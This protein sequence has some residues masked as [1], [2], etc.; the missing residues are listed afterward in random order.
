MVKRAPDFKKLTGANINV[1]G[2]PFSDIYPKME[3]DF[4]TG[5]NS[6]DAAVFAPQWM[7]DFIEPGYFEDL[8][9]RVKADSALEWND[10]G[11]FFRSFS[12]TYAGKI[13][14]IPLDGDFH[15]VYYR[16][17]LLAAAG[18]SP[19]K[20]WEEYIYIASRFHGQDMNGDGTPDYGSCISKKR[21]AQAYW[22]ILSI[23]GSHI[24]TKGTGEGIFFDPKTM[25]PLVNNA[26]Y[27]RAFD[28][29][30]ET[31]K[32]AP[33]NEINLDVGDTRGLWTSGRCA[34]TM[35]WGD[36]GTLAIE[37]GSKVKGKTGASILPGSRLVLDR[38][39]GELVSCT[40]ARCPYAINGINH[41]PFAAFG[42]WSGA[43]NTS[44]DS[45]VKDAAYD[46]FSYMAQ[47][48]Q[49][50][51]DVTV[52]I[53][54]MNPYRISQFANINNW[55]SAGFSKAAAE[56]YLGAIKSSLDSPN[57]ILDLRIPK[58]QRYQQVVLD[59]EVHRFISGEITK[60]EAMQR[61]H[62]GWE[63]ITEEMGR[64]TQ[65][66]AYRSTLGY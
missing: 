37:K 61:I 59:T 36:I 60:E 15:M 62:D 33:P 1:I 5:T 45:K 22:M 16:S 32:Y 49:S 56:N 41:A 63:E 30:K 35:D 17:D 47:P 2:V 43:V 66:N 25:K 53:T 12:S 50:N 40:K 57:M 20:T 28:I 58:N 11:L 3:S 4:A 38:N 55:T 52:G 26:A 44:A 34:L 29:Y 39:S 7:V 8:T 64:D 19:P 13:Y 18:I 54:G 46:F 6:V 10:V 48:N 31:T 42:G 23:V 65:L 27:S 9:P 24:Q 21:N 14:T 51:Q